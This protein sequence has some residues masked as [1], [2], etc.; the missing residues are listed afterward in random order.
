M[1]SK[2]L[3]GPSSLDVGNGS[4][5][6]ISTTIGGTARDRQDMARLGKQQELKV[7]ASIM[8]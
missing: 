3:P 2:S 8:R 1:E 6:V 7:S 4:E 5:E